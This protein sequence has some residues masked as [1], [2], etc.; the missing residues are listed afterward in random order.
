MINNAHGSLPEQE[1][2]LLWQLMQSLSEGNLPDAPEPPIPLEPPF[3]MLW[4]LRP[5]LSPK[6]QRYIDL[7]IKIFE[8]QVLMDEI[9]N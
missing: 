1:P 5:V 4:K 2:G 3:D 7:M 6:E 9:N 8:I